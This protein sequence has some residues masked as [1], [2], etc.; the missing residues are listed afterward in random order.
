MG[1]FRCISERRDYPGL[2][3]RGKHA[4]AS[5]NL[6]ALYQ[7]EVCGRPARVLSIAHTLARQVAAEVKANALSRLKRSEA[8]RTPAARNRFRRLMSELAR[9]N[10]FTLTDYLL[11]FPPND[12]ERGVGVRS[13]GW[14]IIRYY[15]HRVDDQDVLAGTPG[16]GKPDNT[17]IEKVVYYAGRIFSVYVAKRGVGRFE[18]DVLQRAGMGHLGTTWLQRQFTRLAAEF[19]GFTYAGWE[20]LCL[21]DMGRSCL[22]ELLFQMRLLWAEWLRNGTSPS[23]GIPAIQNGSGLLKRVEE[24]LAVLF[25]GYVQQRGVVRFHRDIIMRL[26][27]RT[28]GLGERKGDRLVF[29]PSPAEGGANCP[30]GGGRARQCVA[31]STTALRWLRDS[32]RF[33]ILGG[34]GERNSERSQRR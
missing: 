2:Y 33:A 9:Q 29:A 17:R 19:S 3:P 12:D 23:D 21:N 7:N 24:A 4:G 14:N 34:C 20:V 1:L 11:L 5:P 30:Q 8:F 6:F 10:D 27:Q 22:S 16:V 13:D 18:S 32:T 28:I 31:L 15:L 26:Q 25:T